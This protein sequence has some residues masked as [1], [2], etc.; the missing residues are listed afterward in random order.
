MDRR[1]SLP[2]GEQGPGY[3]PQC[4]G[5]VQDGKCQSCGTQQQVSP[6]WA[7]HFQQAAPLTPQEYGVHASTDYGDFVREGFAPMPNYGTPPDQGAPGAV[8]VNPTCPMCG[9][10]HVAGTP[11]PTSNQQAQPAPIMNGAPITPPVPNK[12]TTKWQVV[13]FGGMSTPEQTMG[14]DPGGSYGVQNHTPCPNCG[15]NGVPPTGG[16]CLNCGTPASTGPVT[17]EQDWPQPAAEANS[18]GYSVRANTAPVDD[19]FAMFAAIDGTQYDWVDAEGGPIEEGNQ[20]EMKTASHAIPDKITIEQ[21]LPHKITFIVHSGG[22]DYRHDL[23][24]EQV[25]TDGTIFTPVYSAEDGPDSSDGFAAEEHPVRPGQDSG[26]QQDDLSTPSTVVS[27][28]MAESSRDWL[29]EDAGGGVEVD[30]ALLQKLAGK[31]YSPREQRAFIDES[32]EARNL[33]RLDLDGT[34][35]ITDDDI[36]SAFNW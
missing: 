27:S 8:S 17:S 3:C 23:T 10:S 14:N 31:D 24:K 32:G 15:V 7:E 4:F 28:V 18:P 35:Y 30:P 1:T 36:D 21:V 22:I 5:L 33:D 25:D 13:A 6:N 20:Y 16:P 9:Q 29:M 26:F 11:C 19:E 34:H 2:Q 12:V